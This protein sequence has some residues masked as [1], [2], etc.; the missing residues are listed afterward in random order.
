M[1]SEEEERRVMYV[2]VTRAME[3]LIMTR[4]VEHAHHVFMNA[5]TEVDMV[6]NL[7]PLMDY[8]KGR[9]GQ[10]QQVHGLAGLQDI[11]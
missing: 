4:S 7:I 5:V 9:R 1:E 6:R 11:F 10:S 3:D 8:E 2:A